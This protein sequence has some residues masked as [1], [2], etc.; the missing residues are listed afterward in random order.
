MYRTGYSGCFAIP[1]IM[2]MVVASRS[3]KAA[4]SCPLRADIDSVL[5]V[6]SEIQHALSSSPSTPGH[7]VD[8]NVRLAYRCGY[9]NGWRSILGRLD[10]SL[11]TDDT[12][13]SEGF[14]EFSEVGNDL[15][16][17]MRTFSK[18]ERTYA[19]GYSDACLHT[20]YLVV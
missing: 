1:L 14:A 9:L 3:A 20:L 7:E 4:P 8:R 12:R 2:L 15:S 5:V 13:S 17:R 18:F 19:A 11:L 16:A 10:L 6:I